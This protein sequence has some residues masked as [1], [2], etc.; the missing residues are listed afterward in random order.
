MKSSHF[1]PGKAAAPTANKQPANP[2]NG[3]GRL[4]NDTIFWQI[5]YTA[6]K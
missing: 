2:E 3:A 5:C 4:R 6:T 1:I